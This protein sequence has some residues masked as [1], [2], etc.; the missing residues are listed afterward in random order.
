LN[1]S[2][3]PPIRRSEAQ[4]PLSLLVI[5]AD[6]SDQNRL[7]LGEEVRVLRDAV[8]M[9]RFRDSFSV[10]NEPSTGVQDIP[11]V[12]DERDPMILH[13]SGHGNASGLCFEDTTGKGPNCKGRRTGRYFRGSKEPPISPESCWSEAQAQAVANKVGYVIGMESMIRD[14]GRH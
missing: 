12:L 9:S 14:A 13:F 10:R 1:I 5:S 3:K 7:R 6:P 11:R 4:K 8:T 2:P